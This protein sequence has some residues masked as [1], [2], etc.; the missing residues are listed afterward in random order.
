[1]HPEWEGDRLDKVS[2]RATDGHCTM[3]VELLAILESLRYIDRCSRYADNAVL[4]DSL[5]ALQALQAK[6][7]NAFGI[8]HRIKRFVAD[9]K[10]KGKHVVF[11][12]VPSH[13]GVTGNEKA[14]T[15]ANFGAKRDAVSYPSKLTQREVYRIIRDTMANDPNEKLEE[16]EFAD[17]AIRKRSGTLKGIFPLEE[18]Y[19][20]RLY[21]RVKLMMPLYR[22]YGYVSPI[23]PTCP[24]CKTNFT[25]EHALVTPCGSLAEELAEART[26]LEARNQ[27]LEEVLRDDGKQNWRYGYDI[28]RLLAHSS[29]GHLL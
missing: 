3:T 10:R 21:R 17:L 18:K 24:H 12:H 15:A 25:V 6:P 11:V 9:L 22:Y 14:D 13:T 1:M 28:C 16:L 29:V 4:T 7:K 26:L 5:S 27:P 8:Q 23:A 20:T 19:T 2:D